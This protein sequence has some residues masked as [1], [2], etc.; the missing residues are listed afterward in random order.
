MP[1]AMDLI[2]NA[3]RLDEI[4]ANA[5]KMALPDAAALIVDEAY[6]LV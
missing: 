1:L 3:K 4:G 2:H 5:L 6:K